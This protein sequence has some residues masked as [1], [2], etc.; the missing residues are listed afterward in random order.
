M[1]RVVQDPVRRALVKRF[2]YSIFY[3][4]GT[5]AIYIYSIFQNAQDPQKWKDRLP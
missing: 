2:P 5:D 3:Q 4:E 1:F